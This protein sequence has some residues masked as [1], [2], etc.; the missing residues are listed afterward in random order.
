MGSQ[1]NLF[2]L[3]MSMSYL[4]IDLSVSHLWVEGA[5]K[6]CPKFKAELLNV[7]PHWGDVPKGSQTLACSPNAPCALL[8]L[9]W[10]SL[11]STPLTP[12]PHPTASPA[13]FRSTPPGTPGLLSSNRA[14]YFSHGC[15]TCV[16]VPLS[17]LTSCPALGSS[18]SPQ[19]TL[20]LPTCSGRWWC[21]IPHTWLLILFLAWLLLWLLSRRALGMS[22]GMPVPDLHPWVP[23]APH[24]VAWWM[25]PF[26][27]L[28]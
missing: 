11:W 27:S 9:H 14:G 10:N 17:K 16:H 7:W 19:T 1:T 3:K 23:T 13:G 15:G 2:F 8:C 22:L 12:Y 5:P 21:L 26:S 6:I 28:P 25:S 20:L 24:L 18:S 4:L